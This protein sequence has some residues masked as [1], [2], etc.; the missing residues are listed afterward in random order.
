[1]KELIPSNWKSSIEGL[2][3][4]INQTFE[5]YLSKLKRNTRDEDESWSTPVFELFGHGIVLDENDDEIIA[6]WALPGLGSRDVQVEVS[7]NRLVIRG[8]K[9]MA[10]KSENRHYASYEESRATFAQA[11]SLPC[12]IDRDRV[13]A[14]FKNGLLTV[15][16]PKGASAKSRHIKIAVNA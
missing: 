13:K 16:M 1:M 7:Q 5:R 4:T 12:E 11:V 3:D 6:R 10:R 15:T 9:K 2:R 8:G 14:R